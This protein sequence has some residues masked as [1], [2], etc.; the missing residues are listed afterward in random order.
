MGVVNYIQDLDTRKVSFMLAKN[1]I[2][3]KQLESKSISALELQGVLF[4]LDI[5]LNTY[6]ELKSDI[7]VV[8]INIS[9]LT[10]YSDSMVSLNWINKFV[11]KLDKCQKYSVLV[12][13]RLSKTYVNNVTFFSL[14][15]PSF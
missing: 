7:S 2:V 5:L 13:N 12:K 11:N 3:N 10:L 4:G 9:E 6:Q 15:L 14:P 1:R 8:P